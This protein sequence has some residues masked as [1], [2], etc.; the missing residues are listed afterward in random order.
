VSRT[1]GA[2][3]QLGYVVPDLDAALDVWTRQHGVGPF[4]VTREMV[5][6]GFVYDG[7]ARPP[8]RLA[9]A[10]GNSG[11]L[12]IELIQPLD[13][14]PSMFTDFLQER[15]EGGLQH[16]ASWPRD[17]D[18]RLAAALDA[19]LVVGQAGDSPRGRFVYLRDPLGRHT[20]VEMAEL[21]EARAVVYAAVA[22]AARGW[23]GSDPV[24]PMP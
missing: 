24:R 15:P 7:V 11:D 18:D 8:A 3:R 2:V 22:E 6:T 12:Q 23:D 16:W 21:T 13:D 20:G 9:M 4:F 14:T 1:F 19:G 5:L 17:Y 10:L